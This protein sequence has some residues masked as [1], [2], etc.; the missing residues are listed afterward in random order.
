MLVV[1]RRIIS[2]KISSLLATTLTNVLL[3]AA[4]KYTA[5]L[6]RRSDAAPSLRR[7]QLHC[8][9]IVMME[10]RY[11]AVLKSLLD[12][13]FEHQCAFNLGAILN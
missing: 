7:R 10:P 5:A 11:K 4:H 3:G 8:V 13:N 6:T 2:L 9:E 12:V 1:V